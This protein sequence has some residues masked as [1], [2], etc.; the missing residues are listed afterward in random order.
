MRLSGRYSNPEVRLRAAPA[1]FVGYS[2]GSII[3]MDLAL[4][5]P[6]LLRSLVL[7]DPAFNLK[8]CLTPGLVGAL[9]R[10]QLLRRARG[11]RRGAESWM[12]RSRPASGRAAQRR[13]MQKRSR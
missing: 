2:G 8:R 7:L 3:A 5:R 10:A 4:E 11:E 1:V 12:R 6:D 13:T 9:V